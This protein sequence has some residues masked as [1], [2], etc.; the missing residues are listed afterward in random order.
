MFRIS[1]G[2]PCNHSTIAK[3]YA[4][5]YHSFHKINM[6]R[7]PTVSRRSLK[8]ILET[9]LPAVICAFNTVSCSND[10]LD[11]DE[12]GKESDGIPNLHEQTNLSDASH[13][14]SSTLHSVNAG[15]MNGI[16]S[17]TQ[18]SSLFQPFTYIPT[19]IPMY[20]ILGP[21]ISTDINILPSASSLRGTIFPTTTHTVNTRLMNGMNGQG[22]LSLPFQTFTNI[23]TTIPT[24]NHMSVPFFIS[25]DTNIMPLTSFLQRTIFSASLHVANARSPNGMGV[26]GQLSLPFQTSTN[27]P[28][29]EHILSVDPPLYHIPTYYCL[30]YLSRGRHTLK[31]NCQNNV[32]F[33]QHVQW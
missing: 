12:A 16:G 9:A 13:T 3:N 4:Y 27:I 29:L 6:F 1:A 26:Q 25:A 19:T 28:W 21:S 24:H 5:L 18:Q 17:Q 33:D 22:Q 10:A 7:N 2:P 31:G 32:Y 15:S 20:N 11:G 8:T 23:P 14:A 30:W